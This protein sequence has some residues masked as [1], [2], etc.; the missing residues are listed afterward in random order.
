VVR[1]ND[2]FGSSVDEEVYFNLTTSCNIAES[3]A[4]IVVE[5]EKRRL[6]IRVSKE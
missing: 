1:S 6:G 5:S 4:S 3:A 2:L